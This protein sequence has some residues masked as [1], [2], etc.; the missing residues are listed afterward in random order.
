MKC[1]SS[2]FSF[3]QSAASLLR[4]TS[5]AAERCFDTASQCCAACNTA[6]VVAI[7]SPVQKLASAFLYI[8]HTELK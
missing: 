7:G 2:S 1:R 3:S 8:S 5:S 6:V 4:S